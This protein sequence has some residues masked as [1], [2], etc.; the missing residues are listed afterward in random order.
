MQYD[1]DK[2]KTKNVWLISPKAKAEILKL[3]PL[4]FNDGKFLG[5]DYITENRMQDGLIAYDFL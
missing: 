4:M 1:G 5:N 2:Q 3:N